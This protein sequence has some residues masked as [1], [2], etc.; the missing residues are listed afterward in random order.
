M[1][2]KKFV[3]YEQFDERI[4]KRFAYF[5]VYLKINKTW[6][7]L[8]YYWDIQVFALKNHVQSFNNKIGAGDSGQKNSWVSIYKIFYECKYVWTDH[9]KVKQIL[10]QK[11]DNDSEYISSGQMSL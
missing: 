5:P 3:K 2:Y 11:L 1:R 6:I 8:E 9:V 4:V 7:W 10:G